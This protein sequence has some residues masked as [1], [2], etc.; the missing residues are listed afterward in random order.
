[1]STTKHSWTEDDNIVVFY[2]YRCGINDLGW[3]EAEVL[4]T[5]RITVGSMRMKKQNYQFLET[6]SGLSHPSKEPRQVY[7]QYK[8]V[9]EED[10]RR[11]VRDILRMR[12]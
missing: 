9:P 3:S 10:L 4:R 11:R 12:T 7:G 6:G 5:M 2:L 1:V 8:E